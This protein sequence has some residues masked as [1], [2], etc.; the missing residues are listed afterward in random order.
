M[1]YECDIQRSYQRFVQRRIMYCGQD[2][3][4]LLNL[5][6]C[7]HIHVLLQIFVLGRIQTEYSSNVNYSFTP[8]TLSLKSDDLKRLRVWKATIFIIV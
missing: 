2:V 8:L 1:V 7:S 3:E 6:K 5:W 4:K